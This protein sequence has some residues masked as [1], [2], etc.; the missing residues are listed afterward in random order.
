[1]ESKDEE[2]NELPAIITVDNST[3]DLTTI[4]YPEVELDENSSLEDH[5]KVASAHLNNALKG[6]YAGW[7]KVDSIIGICKLA[8]TQAAI[9]ETQRKLLLKPA[10]Y[11][12]LLNGR[13]NK[14]SFGFDPY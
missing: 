12:E 11:T 1:M 6:I 4:V 13:T 8:S 5:K 14:K 9:L 2:D 10:S 7:G 3:R